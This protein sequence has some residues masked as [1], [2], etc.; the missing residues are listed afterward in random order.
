MAPRRDLVRQ[1]GRSRLHPQ[2]GAIEQL[3]TSAPAGSI[4]V[5]LDEIEVGNMD[6]LDIGLPP[7][8]DTY[9]PIVVKSLVFN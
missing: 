3:Y 4:V 8:G 2:K 1:T 7:E 5:C 6:Y 9:L